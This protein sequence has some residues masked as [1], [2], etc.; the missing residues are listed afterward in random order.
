MLKNSIT[1]TSTTMSDVDQKFWDY[2]NLEVTP[3]DAINVTMRDDG[4]IP[5]PEGQGFVIS[6]YR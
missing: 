4:T 3:S 5:A 6:M 2:F 1:E